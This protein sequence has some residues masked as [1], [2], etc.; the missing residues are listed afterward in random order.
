M[1]KDDYQKLQNLKKFGCANNKL[2]LH[3]LVKIALTLSNE[4]R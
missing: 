4:S 1:S 3:S 2:L